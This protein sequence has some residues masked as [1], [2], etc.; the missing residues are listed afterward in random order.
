MPQSEVRR[1]LLAGLDQQEIVYHLHPS[2]AVTLPVGPDTLLL[3]VDG[4]KVRSKD[5]SGGVAGNSW[6]TSSVFDAI[7]Q[8]GMW[9]R[10]ALS[11]V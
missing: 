4:D 7:R 6:E 8:V 9:R 2:G 11:W 1:K 3:I 5:I 10:E